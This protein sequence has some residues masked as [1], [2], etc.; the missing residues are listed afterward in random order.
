MKIGS[1]LAKIGSWSIIWIYQN[2]CITVYSVLQL[3]FRSK[4]GKTH[5]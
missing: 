1:N 2:W 4:Q 3:E 5:T